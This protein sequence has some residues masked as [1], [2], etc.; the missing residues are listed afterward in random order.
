MNAPVTIS[1][2]VEV[3]AR[4]LAVAHMLDRFQEQFD[5][6]RRDTVVAAIVKLYRG[7]EQHA[8]REVVQLR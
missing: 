2:P 6:Q 1:I 5:V 7:V 3:L 8:Q 4:D